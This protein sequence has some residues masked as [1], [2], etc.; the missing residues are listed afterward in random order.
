[1][2]VCVCVCVC[3]VDTSLPCIILVGSEGTLPK[4][5][6]TNAQYT[7]GYLK[8]SNTPPGCAL[9]NALLVHAGHISVAL[10]FNCWTRTPGMT[11]RIR[12]AVN[13]TQVGGVE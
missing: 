2:C 6:G 12:L 10:L 5:I 13:E 8:C 3:A 4:P 1:M 7:P 9:Q 11:E